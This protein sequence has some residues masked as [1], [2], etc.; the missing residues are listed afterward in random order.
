MRSVAY[1][2]TSYP[3]AVGGVQAHAHELIRRLAPRQ[4]QWVVS[5]W[6]TNRTDWLLGSTV[7]LPRSPRPYEIDGVEVRRLAFGVADRLAMLPAVPC[8]YFAPWAFSPLVARIFRRRLGPLVEGADLVHAFRIGRENLVMAALKEAR[9][10][11][12][13]FVFTPTHHP[14]WVGYRYSVYVHIYRTADT[15]I[16]LTDA[17]RRALV[18]LG[19]PEERVRVTGVGPILAD[20]ADAEGF[21][22][23]Y[24]LDGDPVVLFLGQK[25]RY[26]GLDIL[27]EAARTVWRKCP[28][29]RFLFIGP[30]TNYSRRLFGRYR[31]LRVL[32][33]DTVSCEEKTSALAACTLLALPSW[34]ESFGGVFTEAWSFDKPVIGGRIPAVES[35]VSD[36]EDGLL[37]DHDPAELADRIL[38]LLQDNALGERMGKAGHSKVNR[39]YAWEVLAQKT[40]EIYQEVLGRSSVTGDVAVEGHLRVPGGRG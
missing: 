11:G 13:P 39:F 34:Q 32:E 37:V 19:V 6:D 14:R 31:D 30:R 7:L 33:L 40:H 3:P 8:F 9:K 27:L 22:R 10:R 21:R 25:Y 4:R 5:Q 26:K 23:T 29:T 15:L 16:A 1:I 38:T 28:E 17:E 2:T 18:K 12:I 20:C 36:G 35:V 24:G